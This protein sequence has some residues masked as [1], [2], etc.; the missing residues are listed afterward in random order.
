MHPWLAGAQ[1][2]TSGAAANAAGIAAQVTVFQAS[3]GALNPNVAGSFGSGR[4]EIN[5]DGV[6]DQFADPNALPGGFFNSN[7]PRGVVLSTPGTNVFVSA[8]T[9]NPTLTPLLFGSINATY[10]ATFLAFSPERIFTAVGSNIVDVSFFVPGSNVAAT[11]NGF[12][13]V[14]CNVDNANTTSIEFFDATNQSLG[15]FFA[16]AF[17]APQS[18]SF[19]GVK[20]AGNVVRRVRLANGNAAPGLNNTPPALDVVMMDDF[21]YGEPVALVDSDQDGVSDADDECPNSNTDATVEIQGCQTSVVNTT[22][23]NGCT[24]NDQLLACADGAKNHGAFVSCVAH[25]ANSLNQDGAIG[26]ND[27]G[28]IVSC[29]ARSKQKK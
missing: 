14:F 15:K 10:P 20:F 12:G 16:P 29:A 18:F 7:S 3:L 26:G 22:G 13:A 8:K 17:S 28:Q 5:W 27:V 4:R 1:V 24:I 6:P 2:V 21:I 23:S 9:G 25:V 11:V 19:L